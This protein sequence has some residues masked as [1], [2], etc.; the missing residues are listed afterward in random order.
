M[1]A[2]S[3]G[4]L[5]DELSHASTFANPSE[6]VVEG[7]W[8]ATSSVVPI[9]SATPAKPQRRNSARPSAAASNREAAETRAV[10]VMPLASVNETV[11]RRLDTTL[12]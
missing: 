3:A 7:D 1:S 9:P 12:L 8:T 10:C 5:P 2:C 6:W 4:L 11:Q